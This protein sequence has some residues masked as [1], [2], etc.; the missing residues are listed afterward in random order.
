MTEFETKLIKKFDSID[1]H[2]DSISESLRI[3]S[4]ESYTNM[5]FKNYISNDDDKKLIKD[6]DY[7]FRDFFI[8]FYGHKIKMKGDYAYV[9][10][11]KSSRFWWE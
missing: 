6:W 2:L 9:R 5:K 7:F 8:C 4:A 1:K 11:W 10:K 3:L